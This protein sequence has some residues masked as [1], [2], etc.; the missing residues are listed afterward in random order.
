MN[1]P[2]PA[3]TPASGIEQQ[4]ESARRLAGEGRLGDAE[5]AFTAVLEAAP[6]DVEALNFVAMCAQARGQVSEAVAL[7]ERALAADPDYPATLHALALTHAGAGRLDEA[8]GMACR[9]VRQAPEF[10]GGRLLVAQ[11]L[12]QLGRADEALPVWFRAITTAQAQGRWLSDET[13]PPQLRTAVKQAMRTVAAGRRRVFGEVL[14]PLRARYGPDSLRRVEK[15]LAMYLKELPTITGDPKQQPT[16]L[17]FPDLPTT[18]YFDRALFPWYEALE[19]GTDAIREELRAVLAGTEGVEPYLEFDAARPM[20]KFL[21]G[22]RGTPAWDAF[23]F[24]RHGKPCADNVQRCPQTVAALDATTLVRVREHGPEACFSVLTP[25]SHIL[26]HQGV[27]NTRAVTHLPLIVP[28][29]CALNVSGEQHAWQEGRAITF[30]DTFEH[31]AWNRSGETRVILLF[32]VWNP[33]LDEAE[34]AAIGDL[35][36]AIGDFNHAGEMG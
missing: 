20:E 33:Y 7:L 25:G 6:D 3:A 1:S 9:A 30:D 24:Y 15:C 17:Y 4:R 5:H 19:A 36:G 2:G 11:L 32:D 12:E 26:P 18:R 21:E 16:F 31:E 14:A 27:T 23:I 28:E 35:V 13:T 8:L 29:G 34:R 22:S 10:Y